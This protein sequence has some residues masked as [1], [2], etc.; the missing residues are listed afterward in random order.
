MR[1]FGNFLEVLNSKNQNKKNKNTSHVHDLFMCII[2]E[3]YHT[4]VTIFTGVV[5]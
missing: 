4:N 1:H 3:L 5:R 2:R